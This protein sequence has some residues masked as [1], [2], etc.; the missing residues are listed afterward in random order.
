M[1]ERKI[2]PI[3]NEYYEQLPEGWRLA[4]LD[5][6]HTKGRK[7]IGMEFLIQWALT[8]TDY[9]QVCI[10]SERLTAQWLN[11]FILDKRVFIHE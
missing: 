5:D 11:P 9:Y 2:D 1:T 8:R 10:V 4:S 7:K 6:F 3:G